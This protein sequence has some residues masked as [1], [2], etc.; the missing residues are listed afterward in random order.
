MKLYI[1]F[2]KNLN[3]LEAKEELKRYQPQFYSLRRMFLYHS[4]FT[5]L[6]ARRP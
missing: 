1:R 4:V 6:E 2:R 3:E 5:L